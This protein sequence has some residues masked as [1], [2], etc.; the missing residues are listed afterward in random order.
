MHNCKKKTGLQA[1]NHCPLFEYA[2][3]LFKTYTVRPPTSRWYSEE[4]WKL[5]TRRSLWPDPAQLSVDEECRC[6]TT[7]TK[8]PRIR[9]LSSFTWLLIFARLNAGSV[10]HFFC[11][12]LEFSIAGIERRLRSLRLLRL[13]LTFR[14]R[15]RR[16]RRRPPHSWRGCR[17]SFD[18]EDWGI[19]ASSN[20]RSSYKVLD[21]LAASNA[22]SLDSLS[23]SSPPVLPSVF[24]LSMSSRSRFSSIPTLNSL[25]ISELVI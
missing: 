20:V 2:T 15:R 7:R 22:C 18:I 14:L 16:R 6:A 19:F 9:V 11:T 1:R 17:A 24:S 5:E 13:R 21:A 8:Y 3:A 23:S 4:D 12:T 25:L 10:S